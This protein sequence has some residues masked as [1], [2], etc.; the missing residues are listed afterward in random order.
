MKKRVTIPSTILSIL[1]GLLI[2]VAGSDG[3][4][5][6]NG[7]SLFIICASVSFVL[8]WIIF[9]PSFAFQTEHYF[10][11]TGSISYLSAVALA[12][13][14][15]PSV[16]PRDLLIGLLIVVWAVR[17]GSFLFMRVKQDGKDDRF[18]IMKTQFH[19]FLMTWTLGGLWVFLTM[20]AGLAAITSNTTQPFG[21]MAYLGLALWIF[22]FSIEVIADRQKRAFKKN[23]QKDKEFI[24]SGLWAWSR[25]PNYFG[26]ITLWIG[27]TLIA[28]PVLSGWQLVTLISPVFVYILLT[29]ISGIPLLENRGMKKWG[30]D[31]EY[32]DYVNRTPALILK[33]PK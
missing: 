22:G 30:S 11:L 8:H 26:E 1:I 13:Y 18:T 5:T 33:K 6:Y 25:H 10:D 17:L 28:L 23:Q 21:L 32:I 4:E 27:L 12:F 15:N 2:A 19:W 9:I 7:M 29:K 20:A 24:T 31:P 16:D 14:L 3:S